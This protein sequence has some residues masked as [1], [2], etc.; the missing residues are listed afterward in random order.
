[1]GGKAN[2]PDDRGVASNN[3]VSDDR[4]RVAN[5]MNGKMDALP[6]AVDCVRRLN[7]IHGGADFLF[8]SQ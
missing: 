8:R 6:N 7:A 3:F 5:G 4:Y 1:M 2:D